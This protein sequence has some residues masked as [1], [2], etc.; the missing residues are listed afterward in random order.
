[1][2]RSTAGGSATRA[3]SRSATCAR[4]PD[5]SPPRRPRAPDRICAPRRRVRRRG[6]EP[7]SWDDA[8]DEAERL[9]RA[10]EG[11][12]VTA[13]SGSETVEQAFALGRLL[14]VGLSSH[15]ALL[16]DAIAD[17]DVVVVL[18][19]VPVEETAPVVELWIKSARRNGARILTELDEEAVRGA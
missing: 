13:F 8:L 14:R 5:S 9:L 7:V 17:A 3:A 19:D 4:A 1:M 18:G 10:S 6:F 16:P 2:P 15:E 12:I 11:R